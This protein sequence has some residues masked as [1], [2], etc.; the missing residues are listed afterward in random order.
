MAIR[1]LKDEGVAA[2]AS[3]IKTEIGRSQRQDKNVLFLNRL[4]K[5]LNSEKGLKGI[6]SKALPSVEERLQALGPATGGEGAGW[7]RCEW[8]LRRDIQAPRRLP[9][10]WRSTLQAL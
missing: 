2:F 3:Y 10:R 7:G 4:V 5:R 8:G 1:K 6:R 9:S